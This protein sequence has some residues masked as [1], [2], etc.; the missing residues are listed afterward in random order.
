MGTGMFYRLQKTRLDTIIMVIQMA[1]AYELV[2]TFCPDRFSLYTL[3]HG[4][5]MCN[6]HDLPAAQK[7][8]QFKIWS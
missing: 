3:Q 8:V 2:W 7:L 6:N 1:L 4:V 5:A